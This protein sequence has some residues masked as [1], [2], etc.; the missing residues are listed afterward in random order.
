MRSVGQFGIM[1][2]SMVDQLWGETL[3]ETFS[4]EKRELKGEGKRKN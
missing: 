4:D 3:T 1:L 2:V